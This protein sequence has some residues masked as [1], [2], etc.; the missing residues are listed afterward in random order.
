MAN[1]ARGEVD[2]VTEKKTYTLFLST[3]AVC[4]LQ[5]R[6]GKTYGQVLRSLD[7][8]DYDGLRELTW[9][10]LKKYH[11][12]EFTSAEQIGDWLDDTG[13]HQVQS[14]LM[15]LFVLNLPPK[16]DQPETGTGN[17]HRPRAAQAG[18]GADSTST[19]AETD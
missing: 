8:L 15:E 6:T 9:A 10:V 2:L 7:E 11:R 1:P 12:K 4:E 14:A 13:R 16:E 17:G 18:T 5:K 19:V 3:N